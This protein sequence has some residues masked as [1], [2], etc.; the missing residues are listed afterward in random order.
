[1]SALLDATGELLDIR[2][3]RGSDVA[4]PVECYEDAARTVPTDLTG[5]TV[6]CSA[7]ATGLAPVSLTVSVSANVVT[8][9]LPRATLSSLTASEW[10]YCVYLTRAGSREPLFGGRLLIRPEVGP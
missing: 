6:D 2:V 8:L 5:A 10:L 9:T 1:M 7:S 3:R 4:V